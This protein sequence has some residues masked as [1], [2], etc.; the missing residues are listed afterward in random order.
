MSEEQGAGGDDRTKIR[1]V[2]SEPDDKTKIRATVPQAED[3]TG[4][5]KRRAPFIAGGIALAAIVIVGAI[6][7]LSGGGSSS[8]KLA[9]ANPHCDAH[10]AGWIKDGFPEP[11]TIES[12]DG[13]LNTTLTAT[14][15]TIHVN[16][17]TYEGLHYNG[18]TPGPT[19]A[20]CRGDTVHVGLVNKL[21]IPT[22][23]HVHGLHVSPEGESDNI[24]ISLNPLQA[25]HYTYQLPLDQSPGTFW[26]HPHYHPLVDAETTGGMLGAIVVQGGLDQTLANIPQRLIVIHGGKPVPPGGKPLPIPGV[27]PSQIKPPPAPGPGELLVNGAY[28][29]TLHISPGQLQRWR[30][31][32]GTGERYVHLALPGTTFELL[33]I[34]GNTLH[35]MRPEKQILIGP[36]ER[37]EV[38]VRGGAPGLYSLNSVPFQPCYK[39]CFDPFGGVPNTGRNFGFQTLVNV[40]SSGPA[41]DTPMPAGPLANPPDL[42]AAHVDVHRTIVMGRVPSFA[43]PPQ[44]PLNGKLFSPARTDITM[45]LGS[46]EE[47]TLKSPD[48]NVID[49]WHNFHIHINPFQ[50]VAINGKPLDY[51]DWQDTVN[52]PNGGSVT[53]LIHPTDFVGRSVFHCHVDFHEDNGMM[54]TFQILKNPPTSEIQAAKVVYMAPPTIKPAVLR[55][56]LASVHWAGSNLATL[57]WWCE[58]GVLV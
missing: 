46:V 25:H 33:A 17:H 35:E 42:R 36:G 7:L 23:L 40:V 13:E 6:A 53:I 28:Q 4:P 22:N 26:Y 39:G 56:T 11:P 29:P 45:A 14:T 21:P 50:V 44:F 34:D 47:W 54:G 15:Y 49:E 8:T 5:P 55:G 32:N 27:K 19:I 18:I 37:V 52:V 31:V 16:H 1:K 9:S 2:V 12:H 20:I 10:F 58:S 38:L 57:L 3:A 41:E 48:N 24:F 30:I 43:R 51:V